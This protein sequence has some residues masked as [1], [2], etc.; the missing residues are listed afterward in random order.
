[1]WYT[2]VI[3]DNMGRKRID[4][5]GNRYGKL[6]VVSY[7]G[8]HYGFWDCSC[9]CGKTKAVRGYSLRR[10]HT[11]S[12]GHC[13]SDKEKQVNTLF[14]Y[15][16]QGA[17]KRKLEWALTRNEFASLIFE[18]CHYCGEEYSNKQK[19]NGY[20]IRYNGIDRLD[21]DL[22]Y[23][24]A[25]VVACCNICNRA[26]QKASKQDFLFWIKKVHDYNS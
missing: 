23:F 10:G 19:I 2:G 25:N 14:L 18:P 5:I 22:S 7:I 13:R 21:N 26:K 3:G 16:R 8:G 11:K 4:E 9:D 20:S 12:C 17:R 1:M 15:Y 6:T 24:M